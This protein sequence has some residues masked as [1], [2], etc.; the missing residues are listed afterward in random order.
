MRPDG[1][2]ERVPCEGL[3]EDDPAALGVHER[4][5]RHYRERMHARGTPR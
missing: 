5:I 3:T 1:S 4:L 2:Y